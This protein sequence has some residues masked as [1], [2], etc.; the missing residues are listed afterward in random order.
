MCSSDVETEIF[1][2]WWYLFEFF[3]QSVNQVTTGPILT[4]KSKTINLKPINLY[5]QSFVAQDWNF[6]IL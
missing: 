3:E 2:G 1:D 4:W 5:G 6:Q